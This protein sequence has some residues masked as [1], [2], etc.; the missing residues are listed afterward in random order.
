MNS[1]ASWTSVAA[2]ATSCRS[3]PESA[4]DAALAPALRQS[5]LS[6]HRRDGLLDARRRQRA[7]LEGKGEFVLDPHAAERLVGI[8]EILR[9]IGSPAPRLPG[10]HI[11]PKEADPS[12][13]AGGNAAGDES[14]QRQKERGFARARGAKEENPFARPDRQVDWA[15]S[16]ALGERIADRNA[17]AT[18]RR[19]ASGDGR[20]LVIVDG[21]TGQ[22]PG[23]VER[24][25]D[26]VPEPPAEQRAAQAAQDEH[27]DQHAGCSAP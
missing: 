6:H 12:L 5:D 17:A 23:F 8:L 11:S 2:S 7:V 19:R 13:H 3:P 20:T 1:G 24:F 16:M 10:C 4:E 25:H 27:G 21:Q 9:H 22:R 15:D 18:L 14:G 26:D